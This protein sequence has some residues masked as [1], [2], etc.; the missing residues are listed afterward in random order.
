VKEY[1]QI[2]GVLSSPI[3]LIPP[4]L[5]ETLPFHP[6]AEIQFRPDERSEKLLCQME[7]EFGV[8]PKNNLQFMHNKG[9]ISLVYTSRY[10]QP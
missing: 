1:L 10:F 6:N 5:L 3:F 4:K 8:K 9:D 7:H 2:P